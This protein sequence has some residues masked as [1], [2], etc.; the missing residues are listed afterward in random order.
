VNAK[1]KARKELWDLVT[2]MERLME[3][4]MYVKRDLPNGFSEFYEGC[5]KEIEHYD[6]EMK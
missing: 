3:V 4:Y 1:E 6:E 2:K 5:M